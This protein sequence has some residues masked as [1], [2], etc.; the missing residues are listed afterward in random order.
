MPRPATDRPT[1]SPARTPRGAPLEPLHLAPW[2]LAPLTL[3]VAA[4]LYPSHA[5]A[6]NGYFSN[7][8]GVK[9]QG[10]GGAGIALPL[11]G[12]AAATNPA[13]TAGVEDRIDLGLSWFR[14]SRSATIVG[15]PAGDA[16]YS[17]DGKKNFFIPEIGYVKRLSPAL[18]TGV[19]VY[20]N[21]GLN[22]EYETNPY[23]RFGA[24]GTAGVN[25]EQ[26]FVSPSVAWTPVR[27]QSIGVALNL[28]YQ[29][30]AAKGIGFFGGF[31]LAP[32]QVSD[33][34]T[35]T[36]TGVGARVGWRGA[37][38]PGLTLGATW[39]S[40]INGRFEKYRGL[41]ANDGEFDIPENYGIG[42]A[43]AAAPGISIA[44]DVQTIRYSKVAA[45]G[46]SLSLL[47]QGKAL[48]SSGGPGFGWRDVTVYK[49][50]IDAKVSPDLVLRAGF[51]HGRQPVPAS[52]T[53]FN[54]LAP[55]VV[56]NHFT[57]GATWRLGGGELTGFA[58]YAPGKTVNGSG[59]IPPSF[60][61]GEANVRLKEFVIGVGYG[62]RL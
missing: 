19:A 44:T 28:A 32:G 62:W 33:Q 9:G 37:V 17:G 30:F 22:T 42:L 40:K 15:N 21:G 25:L 7:G 58:A 47:L 35:D 14:P 55:G 31:S 57:A 43:F 38:A 8:Y 36:S 51:S 54:I 56:E 16:S 48:G 60:G 20:G 61:G 29:R 10:L 24:S 49:V 2:H 46:N 5:L 45:V 41:F 39:A 34:G 6:T 59:S 52:E 1:A 18:S 4:L 12:L 13:G 11:D 27:D 26:L 3:I 23:G 53:F 50:G